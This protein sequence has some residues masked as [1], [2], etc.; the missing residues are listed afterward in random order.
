M[1]YLYRMKHSSFGKIIQYVSRYKAYAFA[2]ILFNLLSAILATFVFILLDPFLKVLFGMT[3]VSTV[4]PT[5]TYSVDY[6]FDWLN[7]T[8]GVY[9]N[10]S[11]K[12]AALIWV[13]KMIALMF[14][15][16]NLF[17]YLAIILMGPV[18]KGVVTDIRS[19]I[20]DK[21]LALPLSF[22]SEERKG[23]LMGRI[24]ADVVEVEGS[25]LQIIETIIKEPFVVLI[26]LVTV[27]SINTKLALFTLGP[28]LIIVL[29][30]GAIGRTLKKKS[31][32]VQNKL[33]DTLSIIDEAISGL[34]IIQAFNAEQYQSI[35]FREEHNQW[36]NL[37]IRLIL[38]NGLASPVTEFLM[39]CVLVCL[40]WYGGYLVFNG[41]LEA[42]KFFVFIGMF[43]NI[44]APVKS[45]S[46]AFYSVQRGLGA[47]ERIDK[48]LN[49][50]IAIQEK[51]DAIPIHDF[52]KNIHYKNVHFGYD[53]QTPVLKGVDLVIPWQQI[54][55]CR[56]SCSR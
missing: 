5:V 21:L 42:S 39:I 55:H 12:N 4:E 17:R 2:S 44:V 51:I 18:R 31:L 30:V 35:K 47:V 49:A 25:I 54:R 36:K 52:Q 3:E 11:G 20:F 38:R 1:P 29:I 23:D 15:F 46:G 45:L 19:H 48:I 33:G 13:C 14:L 22:F 24:T 32:D 50:P 53:E 8:L 10:N 16:K 41:D 9:I 7:Y 26:S 40:L 43:Y 56:F 28:V 37:S 34:R 27:F 6:I